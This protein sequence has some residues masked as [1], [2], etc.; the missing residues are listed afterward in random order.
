MLPV[1]QRDA[2]VSEWV[3]RTIGSYP[4]QTA[5]LMLQQKDPFR[6]PAGHLYT[7]GLPALFDQL[8]GG[9]ES[10][11]VRGLLDPIIRLRAVQDFTPSQ[12]VGFVVLLK[13]VIR[14]QAPSA[15]TAELSDR[16]DELALLAFDLFM[17]CREESYAIRAR[18]AQRRSFVSERIHARG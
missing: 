6:N 17:T 1:H 7:E 16:I 2:I 4:E 13:Q 11:R 3:A 14:D 18:E 8:T 9:W 12:A 10:E 5:R 15:L